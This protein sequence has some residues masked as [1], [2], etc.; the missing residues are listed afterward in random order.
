MSQPHRRT[1]V[2]LVLLAAGALP[3]MLLGVLHMAS[4]LSLLRLP[5]LPSVVAEIPG[6]L[7]SAE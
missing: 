3:L 7:H 2:R 6:T 5:F 1:N 4:E